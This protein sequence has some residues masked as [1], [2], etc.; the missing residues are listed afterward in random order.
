MK[1]ELH[2]LAARGNRAFTQE[3]R[4]V[5]SPAVATDFSV[6]VPP[7]ELWRVRT[8][9]AHLATDANVANRQPSLTF[10]DQTRQVGHFPVLVNIVASLT[11]EITWAA[12]YGATPLSIFGNRIC[13]PL[14]PITIVAGWQI[15]SLTANIQAGDQWSDIVVWADI[16]RFPPRTLSD[17]LGVS[18]DDIG[19]IM[20]AQYEGEL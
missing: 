9:H 20:Q 10:G 18:S 17:E 14:S 4:S 6:T 8:V 15:S 3:I 13:A 19:K 5:P 7:G 2:A 12:G 1:D 16:L 11:T